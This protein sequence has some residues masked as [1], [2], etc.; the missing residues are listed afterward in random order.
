LEAVD[1]S[2]FHRL[3]AEKKFK[4]IIEMMEQ[5]IAIAE[6]RGKHPFDNQ[7]GCMACIIRKKRLLRENHPQSP[8]FL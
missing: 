7:C 8:F 6:K 2:V 1:K 5:S 3:K 4:Q